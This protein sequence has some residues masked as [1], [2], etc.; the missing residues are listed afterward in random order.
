MSILTRWLAVSALL[1]AFIQPAA[2]E[3]GPEFQLYLIRHAE[4][5][6]DEDDPGLTPAG[7]QRSGRLAEWF[8]GRGLETIWSSDYRRTRDTALP[9][10]RVLGLEIALYDPRQLEPFSETLLKRAESALVVGHSNTTPELAAILC[11][12]QVRP[13]EETEH[14]RII[15]ITVHGGER[16]LEEL[17]QRAMGMTD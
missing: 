13:M 9:S 10:A 5:S 4:K 14:D 17:D 11:R 2:A 15:L 7:Q 12:C 1:A 6:T 8:G 3:T 16:K